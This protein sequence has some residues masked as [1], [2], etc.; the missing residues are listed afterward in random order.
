MD[1][2]TTIE[3][4]R[5]MELAQNQ[6]SAERETEPTAEESAA[7]PAEERFISSGE[8]ILLLAFTGIIAIIS[9]AFNFIPYV[10]WVLNL[11]INIAVGGIL[12]LWLTGKIA[13]GAPKKWYKAIYYGA[14]GS[15]FGGYFGAIIWLLIQDRKILGKV[16]GKLGEEME[17]TAKKAI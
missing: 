16:A 4:Q 6:L 5:A 14:A 15:F 10:G 9:W 11:I 8:A 7:K 12:L 17:K 3:D 1:E 2:A 13:K